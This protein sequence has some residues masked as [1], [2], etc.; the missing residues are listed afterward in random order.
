MQAVLVLV[1]VLALVAFAVFWA[2]LWMGIPVERATAFCMGLAGITT[3][4]KDIVAAINGRWERGWWKPPPGN[5]ATVRVGRLSSL[6]IGIWFTTI[7][8]AF[9]GYDWLTEHIVPAILGALA[10]GF[11]LML[12]GARLDR[13]RADSTEA[14]PKT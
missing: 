7:G 12:V 5:P 8:V 10:L 9:L 11:A 6:G 3:G 1:M 2:L 14:A 4:L 13:R